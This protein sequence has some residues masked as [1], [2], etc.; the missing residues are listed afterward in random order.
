M[1]LY[2]ITEQF[3]ELESL[4]DIPED[5][6]ADTLEALQG[7]FK[8]KAEN[9]GYFLEN[10]KADI[11]KLKSHVK[12]IQ[13][14]IK[15]M[16]NREAWLKDYLRQNME[17]SGIDKIEC[18]YFKISL[19]A[20][21]EVV[22]VVDIDLLDEK[23][24]RLKREADKTVIKKDLKSGINIDGAKLSKGKSRLTIK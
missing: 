14:K 3:K 20:P 15:T 24:V 8:I 21:S 2:Q 11:D 18:P 5:A 4:D 10:Q 1:K 9:L 19:G 22:E 16:E 23:Y 7:E 6:L 12:A 13:S 17:A